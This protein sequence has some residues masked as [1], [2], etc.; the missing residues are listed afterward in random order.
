MPVQIHVGTADTMCPPL[1]SEEIRDALQDAGK[2]VE[3]FSYTGA[4]HALHGQ[5]WELFMQRVADFFNLYVK[6]EGNKY[7]GQSPS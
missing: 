2:D 7:D 5:D 4:G 1:W 3:Y 6:M